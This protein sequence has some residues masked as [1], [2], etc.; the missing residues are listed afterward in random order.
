MPF[1]VGSGV[2][3]SCASAAAMTA[4][5]RQEQSE[6]RGAHHSVSTL[7]CAPLDPRFAR[8]ATARAR[9]RY[10]AASRSLC[11]VTNRSLS[12]T[13]PDHAT[14]RNSVAACVSI[15]PSCKIWP[16]V[17]PALG[18]C[19]S[20]QQ[21][22][23]TIKRLALGAHQAHSAPQRVA[24]QSAEARAEIV[25]LRHRLVIG[26]AVPI[27]TLI[28]RPT[29]KR[30][31]IRQIRHPFSDEPRLQIFARKPREKP[32]KGRRTDIRNGVRA[33][34]AQQ[35]DETVGRDIGVTDAE[36]IECRHRLRP[37]TFCD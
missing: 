25:L 12:V 33:G 24:L 29:A 31:A 34:I 32:R 11:P 7:A 16:M 3:A 30:L 1:G 27:K 36:Q 13:T 15:V 14:S 28:L 21:A 23:V 10:A 37:D 4:S 35:R 6:G 8:Y 17:K 26:D 20:D 9:R 22:A 2:L 19:A 18:K 5:E